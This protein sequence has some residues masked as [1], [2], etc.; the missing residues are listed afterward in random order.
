MSQQAGRTMPIS[1]ETENRRL[2]KKTNLACDAV[3]TSRNSY[4][5]MVSGIDGRTASRR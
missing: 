2:S 1:A 5:V 4:D 3:G